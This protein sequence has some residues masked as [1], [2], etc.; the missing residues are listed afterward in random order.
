MDLSTAIKGEARRLGF[1]LVGIAPAGPAESYPAYERW[2]AAGY[3]GEMD[4]L[5]RPD[6]RARRAD[7]QAVL[8]GARSWIS[9]ACNY[10]A[11]EPPPAPSARPA[12]RVARYARGE[13]YHRVFEARLR[14]L[15]EWITAQVPEPVRYKIAVDTS[16]V[17]E[18][19]VAWRA[20]LGWIGKNTLLIHPRRGS[21]LL[22]G[23]LLLDLAL[24]YDQ[25]LATDLCGSCTRCL[26][27]CPTGCILPERVLDATRCLAY[28]TIEQRGPIPDALAAAAGDWAF[29][30]DICQEV[31]PWNVRFATESQDPA[32]QPGPHARADLEEWAGQDEQAFR[33]RYGRTALRHARHG[34]LA[35]NAAVVLRNLGRRGR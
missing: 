28:L 12:G 14:A 31:C 3:H 23:E 25:P 13:D 22:L 21:W 2:L 5:A 24:D 30:C 16:A 4:Y 1:D 10:L 26:E 17:L 18:R 8:P 11:P 35:R 32:W 15:G 27:A 6:A 9:V 19:E 7:P 34:G 33:T 20:G 29:G